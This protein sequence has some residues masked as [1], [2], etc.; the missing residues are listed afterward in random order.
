MP[1]II[2]FALFQFG[3]FACVLGAAWALPWAGT[4]IALAIVTGHLLVASQPR[5]E[6]K[7]LVIAAGIGLVFDSALAMLGWIAFPT[8][9]LVAGLAPHWMV[10]LWLLFATTL[11]VSLGWLKRYPLLSVLFGAVGGPLAYYG[12]SK[13]GALDF[14]EMTPAL[15]ALAI[16]W[17]VIT[18]LLV[19]LAKRFD[20]FVRP[21]DNELL[22]EA[23]H[24]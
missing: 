15:I 20:G 14:V 16:G 2:N 12:G 22:S 5:A 18:P 8:G 17:A 9:V 24:G 6:L 11:N 10:A 23:G 21:L 7:L 13:L 4:G 19:Q 3:W 1:A